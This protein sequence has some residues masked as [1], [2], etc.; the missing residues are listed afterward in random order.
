MQRKHSSLAAPDDIE[1][2]IAPLVAI[3]IAGTEPV[4]N[5][6]FEKRNPACLSGIEAPLEETQDDAKANAKGSP[7]RK[8]RHKGRAG[9]VAVRPFQKRYP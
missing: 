9:P 1:G 3:A 8:R 7:L 2:V 5:G 4:S 6:A